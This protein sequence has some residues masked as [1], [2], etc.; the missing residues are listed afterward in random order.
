MLYGGGGDC[1]CVC[2]G[3]GGMEGG[4]VKSNKGCLLTIFISTGCKIQYG[5]QGNIFFHL[6]FFILPVFRC[7]VCSLRDF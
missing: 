6:C 5:D 3:G 7:Q 2:G 4:A 1:V